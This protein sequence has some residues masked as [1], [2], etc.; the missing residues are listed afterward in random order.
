MLLTKGILIPTL[1]KKFTSSPQITTVIGTG[2]STT[3]QCIHKV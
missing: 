1:K 2:I 3:K